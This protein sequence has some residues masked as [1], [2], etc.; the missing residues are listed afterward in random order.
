MTSESRAPANDPPRVLIVSEHA[1]VRFGGE[2]ILPWHYFR[3]LRKRG[4]EAWLVVHARTRAEL[5]DLLPEESHRLYFIP[6]TRLNKL[7]FKAGRLMPDRV[8][9]LTTGYASRL[10]TQITARS[11][12]RRLVAEHGVDVVHQ[13]I[14]VS[15]R[16]PSL[17]HGLGA[18]VVIGPMN[19][20]MTYPPAFERGT[21]RSVMAVSRK[22]S[23]LLHRLMPGKLRAAALL[24]ANKRTREALPKAS[25]AEVVELVENGVDLE[26]WTLPARPARLHGPARFIFLGRLVDWKAVDVLLEALA[27]VDAQPPPELEILGDGPMRASLEERVVAL[28]LQGRVHFRGWQPQVECARKLR[29]ADA[30]VLSSLYECG[31]AVVLEAMASGLPVVATDWGGPS[32]YLDESC[33]F[34]IPPDSREKLVAGFAEA[35]GRL[36]VDP[37]LRARLGRAG[38]DRVERLFD[39]EG[40]IDEILAVYRR[41]IETASP[42]ARSTPAASRT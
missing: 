13:P 19:G 38:R 25:R 33:G 28:G 14:P 36:A 30:L 26:V 27:R 3:L 31:G 23:E 4:V 41:A 8:A 40:K 1:S 18:P 21:G 11:L 5:I 32:D 37:D 7:A 29:E 34:L 16:E 6:D 9:Y 17:L 35:M 22:A 42:D 39:W 10:S 2:A 20:N 24:V 15:P 12:A